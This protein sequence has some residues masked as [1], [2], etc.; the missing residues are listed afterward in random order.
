MLL[1]NGYWCP[2]QM[3]QLA[4]SLT[5]TAKGCWFNSPSWH[6]PRLQFDPWLG[7]VWKALVDV[8]L[9]LQ[10]LSLSNQQ[11]KNP[12]VIIQK[13]NKYKNEWPL[14]YIFVLC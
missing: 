2:G 12:R 1:Q 5:H 14:A 10:Y 11:Q 9:S 6:I 7:C 3:A 13:I 8:F 4:G